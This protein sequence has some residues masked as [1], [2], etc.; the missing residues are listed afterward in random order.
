MRECGRAHDSAFGVARDKRDFMR[1]N[2]ESDTP[3]LSEGVPRGDDVSKVYLGQ[4]TQF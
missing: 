1:V 2:S 4:L 3:S